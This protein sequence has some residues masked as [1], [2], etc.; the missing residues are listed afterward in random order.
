L[1]HGGNI[2]VQV[3]GPEGAG[4]VAFNKETGVVDWKSQNDPAS[5]AAPIVATLAGQETFV[6]FT[7]DGLIGLNP[8]DGTL[9]WRRP[10]S[11]RL[12]RHVTTP[13]VVNDI[14]IVASHQLG[15]V[16]TRIVKTAEQYSAEPAWTNAK[17][18]TNFASPVIVG[19][20]LYGLGSAKDLICMDALTGELAWSKTGVVNTAAEQAEAAFLIMGSNILC[21]TDGGELVLY[22]ANTAEYKEISR[23]QV[24]GKN[25]CNPA[26][27]Q[28][29]LYLRDAKDLLCLELR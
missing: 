21:L 3:G 5:Y 12:G 4:V 13:V 25:W 22:A 7:V 18:Q 17:V 14:V 1:I 29:Q 24:C 19:T 10:L 20:H 6:S 27:V 15:V 28:G 8:K 2:I 11:T 26:Y 23:V 9:L 16:A